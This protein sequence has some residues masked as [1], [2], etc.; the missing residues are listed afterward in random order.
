MSNSNDSKSNVVSIKS[1]EM[2]PLQTPA[3]A[4]MLEIHAALCAAFNFCARPIVWV[5][6]QVDGG[7]S[8]C[9]EYNS[10]K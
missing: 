9:R 5:M 2:A 7:T 8:G 6:E 10:R 4:V 1:A 3:Q